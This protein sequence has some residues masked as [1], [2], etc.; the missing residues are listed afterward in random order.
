MISNADVTFRIEEI[1]DNG[2]YRRS[3]CNESF[4]FESSL[5]TKN[6]ILT[7]VECKKVLQSTV[8]LG[9]F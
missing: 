7:Y 6:G 8:C 5:Y 1:T 4:N 3:E 9:V 2:P